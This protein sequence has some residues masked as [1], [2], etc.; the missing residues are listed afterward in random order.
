MNKILATL[1]VAAI[2]P[3]VG[4]CT[5]QKECSERFDRYM[6]ND[7]GLDTNDPNYQQMYD[8]ASNLC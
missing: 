1:L 3:L 8:D 6:S 7:Y 4:A 2:L 5:S